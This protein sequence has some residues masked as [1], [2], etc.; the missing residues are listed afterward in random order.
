VASETNNNPSFDFGTALLKIINKQ[1]CHNKP[2]VWVWNIE[3]LA[4][5][6]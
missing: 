4:T 6:L 1:V 2:T 3:I 5:G